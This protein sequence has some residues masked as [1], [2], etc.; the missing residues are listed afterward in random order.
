VSLNKSHEFAA[1]VTA[2]TGNRN[3]QGHGYSRIVAL[4]RDAATATPASLASVA[5]C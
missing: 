5:S 1:R 3:A 4:W 2:G